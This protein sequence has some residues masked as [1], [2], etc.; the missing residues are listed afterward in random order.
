MNTT[1]T[2]STS[3]A[4][5]GPRRAGGTREDGFIIRYGI[6]ERCKLGRALSAQDGLQ[7]FAD[8]RVYI[9]W[10]QGSARRWFRTRA[11]DKCETRAKR[12]RDFGQIMS[13]GFQ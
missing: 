12:P 6:T 9:M 13:Q 4:D 8:I 3:D 5:E 2:D 1:A 10:R 11:L 7:S